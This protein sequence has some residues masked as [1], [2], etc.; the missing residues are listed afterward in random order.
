MTRLSTFLATLLARLLIS[1]SIEVVVVDVL[2][3]E[4]AMSRVCVVVNSTIWQEVPASLRF[5]SK[6]HVRT[7]VPSEET[8]HAL[9]K[10]PRVTC[11]IFVHP[12]SHWALKRVSVSIDQTRELTFEP[13]EH[14]VERKGV[15]REVHP[16]RVGCEKG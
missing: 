2:R 6:Q 11:G 14:I 4:L 5:V 12:M 16:S 8:I 3:I 13:R 15:G 1:V 9:G 7:V 10:L